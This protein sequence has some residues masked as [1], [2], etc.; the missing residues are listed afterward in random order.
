MNLCPL[1]GSSNRCS[2]SDPQAADRACWCFSQTI[3]PAR[4]EALPEH[5]RNTVCLCPRCAGIVGELD[6]EASRRIE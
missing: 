3:E 4:L 2:L 5:L 6:S 1:C